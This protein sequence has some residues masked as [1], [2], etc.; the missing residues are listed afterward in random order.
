[1]NKTKDYYVSIILSAQEEVRELEKLKEYFMKKSMGEVFSKSE[2]T[3]AWGK[4]YDLAVFKI[5]FIEKKVS[6]IIKKHFMK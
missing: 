6:K 2:T 1:M 4:A 5:K 3:E